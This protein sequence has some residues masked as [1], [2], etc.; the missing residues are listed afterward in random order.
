MLFGEI[1]MHDLDEFLA[2]CLE[3]KRAIA[4]KMDLE[5]Y[6]SEQIEK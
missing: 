5:G 1:A 6:A 3:C 2:E 4:V